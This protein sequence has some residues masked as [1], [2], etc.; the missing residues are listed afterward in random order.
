MTVEVGIPPD[1]YDEFSVMPQRGYGLEP[2]VA[3]SATLGKK[4]IFLPSTATRLRL[5]CAFLTVKA[6]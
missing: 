5:L 3:A 4:A 2:R 6:T 1:D